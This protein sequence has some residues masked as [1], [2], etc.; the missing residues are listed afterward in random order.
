MLFRSEAEQGVLGSILLS[1]NDSL[2]LCVEK[3]RRGTQ[4]FYDLRHQT[5]YDK[6]QEMYDGREPIDIIT[7]QQKLKD[8][9]QLDAIGG[10]AYLSSLQ[11]AVPSA[12]NLDYYIGIVREKYLLRRLI[13][14]C[15]EVIGRVHEHEGE[16]DSLL[17]EVERDILKLSEDREES[18]SRTMKELVN[19]AINIIEEDR[20][21]T[22]LNSSH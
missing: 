21:S 3:L 19:Q 18:A 2:G 4:C 20:K 11:D 9:H 16:V 10:L 22:R 15:S 17:D 12:A 14:A 13:K 5:L 8:A 6:L 7:V 1:P